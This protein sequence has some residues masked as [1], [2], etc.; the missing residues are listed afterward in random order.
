MDKLQYAIQLYQTG[1]LQQSETLLREIV[2]VEPHNEL[3]WWWLSTIV[4][5]DEEQAYCLEQ[6]LNINPYNQQASEQL[7]SLQTERPSPSRPTGAVQRL[8][9]VTIPAHRP[10]NVSFED[11]EPYDID[12]E[13]ASAPFL[14]QEISQIYEVITDKVDE[15]LG[16][17]KPLVKHL[18]ITAMVA[19]ILSCICSWFIPYLSIRL[20][21]MM[22]TYAASLPDSLAGLFIGLNASRFWNPINAWVNAGINL[23]IYF[24]ALFLVMYFVVGYRL[25]G[26]WPHLSRIKFILNFLVGHRRTFR[27]HI[28]LTLI[29]F[30]YIF[31]VFWRES[32]SS[33]YNMLVALIQGSLDVLVHAN[34]TVNFLMFSL[35]SFIF[36][37]YLLAYVNNWQM[38]DNTSYYL[39]ANQAHEIDNVY[40][41]VLTRMNEREIPI[42]YQ[43][44]FVTFTEGNLLAVTE[45]E[46]VMQLQI[47]YRRARVNL[48]VLQYGQDLY[49]RWDSFLDLSARRIYL[50]LGLV[51]SIINGILRFFT[52][53]QTYNVFMTLLYIL[54][55]KGVQSSGG[56]TLIFASVISPA[57]VD[58]SFIPS[59]M[60]DDLYVLE[61]SVTESTEAVLNDIQDR[62]GRAE[63][64]K[65]VIERSN[66]AQNR[67][68]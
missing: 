52:G 55:G 39:L 36:V 19:T 22:R 18:G 17:R 25:T 61:D 54:L 12:S 13:P 38:T 2:D 9:A 49:V 56:Q 27:R 67:I 50:I 16:D 41:Y 64:V 65:M 28:I 10:E 37:Y 26:A 51:A 35:I 23:P 4:D 3:A 43:A 34:L 21:E 8:P 57:Y 24:M 46:V 14:S 59:H 1:Y 62:A 20:L 45:Q 40:Q 32:L 58:W 53:R 31:S 42:P 68:F 5:D 47:T 66:G 11:D 44:K 48:R 63:R 15:I 30:L 6:V 60:L 29:I 7:F 33:I